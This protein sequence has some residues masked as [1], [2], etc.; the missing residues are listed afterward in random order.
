M[1]ASVPHEHLQ[2][3]SVA[4]TAA[5]VHRLREP[6]ALPEG[7]D[8]WVDRWI[9][10]WQRRPLLARGLREQ[11]AQAAA[12]CE[13]LANGDEA[14]RT[15]ALQAVREALMRDP[16]HARGRLAEALALVGWLAERTLGMRPYEVQFMG[17]LALHHGHLAEMATGEGKT[18]TV[19][20]AAVLAGWSARPCHVVTA[21]D[22]LAGSRLRRKPKP[23]P[24][25][26]P[27]T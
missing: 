26:M 16:Q 25:A 12:L 13:Q 23:R 17:A 2:S 20:L 11:A 5:H 21:N 9:G 14:A 6:Q 4:S 1:N 18:L 8:A 19:G 3:P 24:S 10:R 15:E 22:Y 27:S 7:L